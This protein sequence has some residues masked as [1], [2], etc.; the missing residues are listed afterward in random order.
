MVPLINNAR[1]TLEW[2]VADVRG[3]FDADHIRPARCCPRNARTPT[4]LAPGSA[5]RRC[6]RPWPAPPNTI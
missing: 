4:V 5:P 2:F 1:A 6:V 3:Q